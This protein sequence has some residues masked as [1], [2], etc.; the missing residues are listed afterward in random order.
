[1]SDKALSAL[2]L[3]EHMQGVVI[4]AVIQWGEAVNAAE[5]SPEGPIKEVN[6]L[7]ARAAGSEVMRLAMGI[8]KVLRPAKQPFLKVEEPG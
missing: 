5:A 3:L 8:A 6:Q 7:R 1:M 2:F 4:E